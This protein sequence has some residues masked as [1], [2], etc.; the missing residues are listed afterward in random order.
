MTPA[1]SNFYK[2]EKKW[3][4]GEVRGSAATLPCINLTL[5]TTFI[6]FWAVNLFITT[7]RSAACGPVPH[8]LPA[9]AARGSWWSWH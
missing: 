3:L 5:W 4:D 1:M 7:I 6:F 8:H 2:L 9:I